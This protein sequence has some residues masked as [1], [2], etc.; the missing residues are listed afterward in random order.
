MR[1][2]EQVTVCGRCICRR[3]TRPS[4]HAARRDRDSAIAANTTSVRECDHYALKAE[5]QRLWAARRQRESY[6]L[7]RWI[8]IVAEIVIIARDE[9]CTADTG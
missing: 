2:V 1:T 8:R 9:I 7:L 3:H 6:L 4:I 5:N